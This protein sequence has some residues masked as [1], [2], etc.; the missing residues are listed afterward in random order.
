[1]KFNV[2]IS[3]KCVEFSRHWFT[4]RAVV[5]VDGVRVPLQ[6]PYNLGTHFSFSCKRIW[7]VEFDGHTLVIEKS[8]PVFFAGLRPQSYRVFCDG[9]LVAE[10]TGY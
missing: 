10:E 8:R 4:G 6:S 1:M 2:T 5:T 3:G 9:E 7:H